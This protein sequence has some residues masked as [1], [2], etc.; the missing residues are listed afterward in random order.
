[1]GRRLDASFFLVFSLRACSSCTR[2]HASGIEVLGV[3]EERDV[4]SDLGAMG[5]FRVVFF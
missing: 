5:F 4:G 3:R 1:M 2:V